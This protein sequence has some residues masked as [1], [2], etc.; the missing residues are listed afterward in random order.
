VHEIG[1]A[2]PIVAAVQQRAGG[3]RVAV[4]RVRAGAMHRIVEDS[5]QAAWEMLASGTEAE[6]ARVEVVTLPVRCTCR[7]CGAEAESDTD[8]VAVCPS[9]GGTAMDLT[10]GDELLLESLT[11]VDAAA[12]PAEVATGPAGA[13]AATGPAG[14]VGA[15][16]PEPHA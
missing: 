15:P 10:G 8:P 11:Y 3:R 6:G 14:A 2:E 12:P 7:A 16:A 9:C 5:M 1:I 4:V 13:D